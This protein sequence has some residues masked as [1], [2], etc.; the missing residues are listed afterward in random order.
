MQRH[1][2][3]ALGALVALSAATHA[4]QLTE[5]RVLTELYDEAPRAA[6]RGAW[7]IAERDI[8][9]LLVAAFQENGVRQQL[10]VTAAAPDPGSAGSIGASL[11][12]RQGEDWTLLARH[13]ELLSTTAGASHG[14]P[15][16]VRLSPR[17]HGFVVQETT[18]SSGESSAYLT[19]AAASD[20]TFVELLRVATEYRG[21]GG[22]RVYRGCG[23]AS[24][25]TLPCSRHT[26]LRLVPG[27][28]ELYD[29]ELEAHVMVGTRDTHALPTATT[30]YVYDGERYRAEESEG[31]AAARALETFFAD[32]LE[33]RARGLPLE[34]F[35]AASTALGPALAAEL[36]RGPLTRVDPSRL[37][38]V[39]VGVRAAGDRA[40]ADAVPIE[41][42]ARG[43]AGRIPLRLERRDGAWRIV[44]LGEAASR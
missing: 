28:A 41:T 6:D 20:E 3:A 36:G 32:W 29:V 26:R 8:A 1:F 11:Y 39:A 16:L 23:P 27:S 14:S 31:E 24:P 30:R 5:E 2:A 13:A 40:T 19:L 38:Y 12:A 9:I 4:R 42:A 37:G 21:T 33:S 43:G 25:P 34:R 44:A 35:A 15:R 7:T 17:R 18:T 22:G 10:F